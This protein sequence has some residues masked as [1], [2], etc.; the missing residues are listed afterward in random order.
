MSEDEQKP[1]A[2]AAKIIK[3]MGK[4]PG[5]GLAEMAEELKE[6]TDLDIEQLR[7]GIENGTLTY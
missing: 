4:R 7:T 3:Y 6:L 5:Q 1:R 2:G